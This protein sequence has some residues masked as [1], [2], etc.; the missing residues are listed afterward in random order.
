MQLKTLMKL[1]KNNFMVDEKLKVY[2]Y[3]D[4]IE[5]ID[6]TSPIELPNGETLKE[7]NGL[8]LTIYYRDNKIIALEPRSLSLMTP[9]N[10]GIYKFLCDII[11]TEIDDLKSYPV[12]SENDNKDLV[13]IL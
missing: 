7:F 6:Y 4:K 1:V 2:I 9:R 13:Q 8:L 11:G 5:F 3:E 12:I 10:T